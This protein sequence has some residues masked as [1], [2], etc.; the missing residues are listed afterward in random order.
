MAKSGLFLARR[1][2]VLFAAVALSTAGDI[3]VE[4]NVLVL[5]KENFDDAL[6]AHKH[7]LV[8]FYA[9]WCGHCKALAPEYAKAA[10][11]LAEEKSEVKLGKVDATEQSELGEKFQVRGYPTLKF[12]REGRPIDYNAGRTAPEIVRWLKKKSGPPAADIKTADELNAIKEANEVVVIGLFKDQESDAAKTFIK[13]ASEYDEQPFVVSSEQSVFDA[14]GG[15]DGQVV[16][17]KKFDEG[18]N[19]LEKIEDDEAVKKFVSVNSL[20]LVVDFTPESAQRVFG[21]AVKSHNLL[22]ASKENAAEY[23]QLRAKFAKA[24][25]KFRGKVLF[26]A[27]DVDNADNSRIMDFFGLKKSDKTQMRMIK[28]EDEMAKFKPEDETNL[29]EEVVAKFV[30]GVLDGSVKQHLLSEDVPADWDAKPVKYLV[31]TKFD[32]VAFD[33]SKHVLVEF[34]APWCGHC[35][36]LEPIYAELGEKMADRDDIVIAKMDATANELEHT[37]VPSFP[38][39]KLY[40]KGTNE[41]IEYNG[42]RT[43]EGLTKFLETD[44]EFGKAP[45]EDT[46]EEQE[47]AEDDDEHAPRD[48]L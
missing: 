40:K 46:T 42:E 33:K 31:A 35:K 11:E 30:Q 23:E 21:G 9:P 17:L 14:A 1:L 28:L 39:I 27:F 18:R 24:A 20:P 41:V 8:E 3:E 48:E 4:E 32:E 43:L 34:Y 19:V 15:K 38:T 6:A 12:F 7:I 36:H 47:K 44:G 16:L 22:F 13:V 5:T 10:T 45:T 29:D 37:K 25:E 26:V 2:V